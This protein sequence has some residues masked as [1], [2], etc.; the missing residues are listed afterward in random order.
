MTGKLRDDEGAADALPMRMVVAVIAI[1][2]LLVLLSAGVHSLLE[3]EKY[4][5]AKAVISQIDS[6][7]QQMTSR[8]SGSII[9]LDVDVPSDTI[10]V[11]GALPDR[12]TEWPSD[13]QNYYIQINGRQ[14]VG[15]SGAFYSNSLLDG[16]FT[17]YSGSYTLTLKSVR[18][19]NGKIFIV[20]ES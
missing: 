9:T 15:E 13:A 4:Y 10:I 18:D 7:A 2:A 12:E 20:I 6:H 1:A 5:D 16:C 17:L 19:Q 3:K 14:T 11:F 8:G